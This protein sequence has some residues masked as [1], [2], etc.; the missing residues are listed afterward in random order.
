M[1]IEELADLA[2]RSGKLPPLPDIV[3]VTVRERADRLGPAGRDLLDVA[4]VAGLSVDAELLRTLR[5]A[6]VPEELVAAGLVERDGAG[7]LTPQ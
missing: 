4:A 5:P 2:A 6:A 3:R 7:F 1:M